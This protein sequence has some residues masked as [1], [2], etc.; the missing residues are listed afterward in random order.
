V[1]LLID[2]EF[3]KEMVTLALVLVT[4]TT[5]V[6]LIPVILWADASSLP[7]FALIMIFAQTTFVT[8][9]LDNALHLLLSVMM[10]ILV[11]LTLVHPQ[12][13]ANSSKR[14]VTTIRF[15]PRI[16]AIQQTVNA[17]TFPLSAT[18]ATDAPM[19]LVSNLLAVDLHPLFVQL[20]ILV[21]WP[22]VILPLEHVTKI[23]ITAMPAKE[24]F[25]PILINAPLLLV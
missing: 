9:A 8:P 5:F 22:L 16:L 1:P 6:L 15:A 17:L 23:Q 25:A 20:L 21:F 13:D 14:T 19:I 10:V 4:T 11:L 18:M 24:S 12:L 2:V 3:V 7:K